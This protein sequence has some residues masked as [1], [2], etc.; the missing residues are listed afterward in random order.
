MSGAE[1]ARLAPGTSLGPYE[2]IGL[3]GAGGMGEVYR[4]RDPRLA[5]EVAI[6]ALPADASLDSA[7]LSRFEQEARAAGALN[8]PNVLAVHDTGHHDGIPYV[9]FELL[10]GETLRRRLE[11]GPMPPAKAIEIAIQIA[12]GLAAAH[13]RG[14]VHRDLKPENVF[15]TQDGRVKILDFGLAKLRRALDDHAAASDVETPSEITGRGGVVG[16]PGYMSPEQVKGQPVDARSDVFAF[17]SVLYELAASRRPFDAETTAETM[18]AILKEDPP[19]LP[20]ATPPALER[21][22]KR[23]LEKR[24]EERFQSAR[25]L[26]AALEALSSPE[27]LRPRSF[28]GTAIRRL[29]SRPWLVASALGIVLAVA[30]IAALQA[31]ARR[32]EAVRSTPAVALPLTAY[33]GFENHPSLSPDGSQVAFSW[34]GPGQDNHDIYVKLVGPGPPLRLTSDPAREDSPAWSPDGRSVAFRRFVTD[35]RADLFVIPALGGQARRVGQDVSVPGVPAVRPLLG[36]LAWTPDGRWLAYGGGGWP[37]EERGLWLVAVDGSAKRRLTDTMDFNPSFSHD[38]RYVAFARQDDAS[39]GSMNV[40]PISPTMAATGAAQRVAS[41]REGGWILNPAW[42]PDG[43][44]LVVARSGFQGVSRL[45]RITLDSRSRAPLGLPEPLPFGEQATAAAVSRTGRLVY[46]AHFRDTSL[47]PISLEGTPRLALAPIAPSTFDEYAPDYSPDGGRLVFVSNRSGFQEIWTSNV[48]GAN[49]AQL[50]TT[51][52]AQTVGPRWSPDGRIAF[53]SR[54]EGPNSIFV[55]SPNTGDLRRITDGR[56]QALAPRWSRDGRWIY[57]NAADFASPS[58]RSDVWKMPDAGGDA[59]QITQNGGHSPSES[60]DGRFVY[61]ARDRTLW[62]LP[63]DGDQETK[64]AER[65]SNNM[66]YV[67]ARRG[68]YLVAVGDA[69]HK[70]SLDLHEFETGKQTTLL[71]IGKQWWFGMALSPDERSL[72]ISTVDSAGSNLMMVD[73]L[74]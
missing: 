19:A 71:E 61:Y 7:R 48:D 59:V 31:R 9:V 51:G 14:I 66:N 70:T 45:E 53:S 21:I 12:H 62:R 28:S 18:T 57:Y 29:S 25:E 38:G 63:V 44:S 13:A 15:L 64:I 20:A 49:P 26:A 1:R 6:K 69:P 67:V 43:R 11:A 35:H 30:L 8:H 74:Q 5:R 73:R 33:P 16:T 4:A 34:D 56:L 68:I 32:G 10:E 40:L 54:R 3:L 72:L 24:P 42:M 23:C 39:G 58:G 22:V 41:T 52:G 46:S 36:N 60:P 27:A 65:L 55:L 17:G 37:P 2:V 47:W 50:T